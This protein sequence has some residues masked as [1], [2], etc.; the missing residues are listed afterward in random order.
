M[1]NLTKLLVAL[2][3]FTFATETFAQR[4][5]IRAGA[6]MSNMLMKDDED[7]YSDDFKLKPGF[8]VGVVGEIAFNDNF[9][10][11]PGLMLTTKGYKLN[12]EETIMGFTVKTDASS[13]PLYLDIPL[14][15]KIATEIGDEVKLY[16]VAGPYIGIGLTGKVKSK[17]EVLGEVEEDNSSISWGSDAD[18]DD[19]KRLDFGVTVGAGAEF[20]PLQAGLFYSLGLANISSYTDGGATISNRV[21]GLNVTWFFGEN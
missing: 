20:G 2:F 5:G 19:L 18:N 16:G 7:T 4:I 11:E 3:I 12:S 9:Y 14:N 15:F 6:V 10:F 1:K 21:M 13:N 17:V 8:T